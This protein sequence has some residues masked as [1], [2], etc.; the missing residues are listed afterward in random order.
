M[1]EENRYIQVSVNRS[2]GAVLR[3][4]CLRSMGGSGYSNHVI[5]VPL[6]LVEYFLRYLSKDVTCKNKT[7]RVYFK[8]INIKNVTAKNKRK[9]TL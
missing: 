8:S 6:G 3:G 4:R 1:K 7:W 9:C 5:A 2:T